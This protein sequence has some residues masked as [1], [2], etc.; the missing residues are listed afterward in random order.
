MATGIKMDTKDRWRAVLEF[1][2]LDHLPLWHKLGPSYCAVQVSPILDMS[3]AELNGWMGRF[4][5]QVCSL[6]TI[7]EACNW[8]NSI[9]RSLPDA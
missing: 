8:V 9:P 4:M 5:P 2:P 3:L 1:A 6:E 7:K